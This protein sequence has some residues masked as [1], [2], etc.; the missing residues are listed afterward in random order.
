MVTVGGYDAVLFGNCGLHA[1][2][3]GLLAVVQMAK[4][5]DELGLVERVGRDLHP[6][7]QRHVAEERHELFGRGLDGAGRHVAPVGGEGDRCLDREGGGV[8]SG[9]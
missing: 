1:D 6:A 5:S 7:H 8:I 9:G 2:G 3:D 4:P